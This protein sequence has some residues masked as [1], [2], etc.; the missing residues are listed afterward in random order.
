M[1]TT[2]IGV[3]SDQIVTTGQ[4]EHEGMLIKRQGGECWI[5]PKYELSETV[6]LLPV[7]SK[8]LW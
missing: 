4:P 7:Y 2:E 5:T 3:D 1:T 6:L 8:E